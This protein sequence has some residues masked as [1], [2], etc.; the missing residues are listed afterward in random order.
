MPLAP[1]WVI[2]KRQ[3]PLLFLKENDKNKSFDIEIKMNASDEEME[4]AKRGTVVNSN[5]MCPHCKNS[6]PM[7]VVRRDKRDENGNIIWGLRRWEK[8]EFI[9]RED[10]VFQERLC[11]IRYRR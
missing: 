4:K 7:S 11:C 5:L 8:N 2:G 6:I 10:D 9:P 1:S 3:E